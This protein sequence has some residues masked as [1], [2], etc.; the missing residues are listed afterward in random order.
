[1][2]LAITCYFITIYHHL[3][4]SLLGCKPGK[5]KILIRI[6]RR[7]RMHLLRG[8]LNLHLKILP[9]GVHLLNSVI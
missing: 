5:M 8:T 9:G 6:E 3:K 7:E 2:P 1:M 4:P